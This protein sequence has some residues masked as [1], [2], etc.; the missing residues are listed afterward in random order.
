MEERERLTARLEYL[1]GLTGDFTTR[2]NQEAADTS[3]MEELSELRLRLEDV[4]EELS[5]RS[6]DIEYLNT[7]YQ[8]T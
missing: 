3:D 6:S 5:Q 1:E 4:T 8:D 2:F 7:V